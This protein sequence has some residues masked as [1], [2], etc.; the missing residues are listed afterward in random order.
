MS[1][2]TYLNASTKAALP[3][4]GAPKVMQRT[5]EVGLCRAAQHAAIVARDPPTQNPVMTILRG[6][7]LPAWPQQ[8]RQEVVAAVFCSRLA[9][10]GT[11]AGS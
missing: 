9:G 1:A 10:H 7:L 4:W 8:S 3:T 5:S 6:V 2:G 11:P